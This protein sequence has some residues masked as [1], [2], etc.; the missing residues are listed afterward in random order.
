MAREDGKVKV[1]EVGE[2][3]LKDSWWVICS[4][5]SGH[6]RITNSPIAIVRSLLG[7]NI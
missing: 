2:D 6:D 4:A 1:S 5:E 3:N 7:I